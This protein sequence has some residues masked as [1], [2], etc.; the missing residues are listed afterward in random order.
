M[1]GPKSPLA[2]LRTR[3]DKD[4]SSKHVFLFTPQRIRPPHL[5]VTTTLEK[6]Y[7]AQEEGKLLFLFFRNYFPSQTG[8]SERFR[9]YAPHLHKL[10]YRVFVVTTL[11]DD[12]P[13][14]EEYEW[15]TV[16]RVGV[17]GEDG[18]L[19]RS[20]LE[21]FLPIL[22]ELQPAVVQVPEVSFQYWKPLR[23]LRRRGH[24]VVAVRTIVPEP[25][26]PLS[27]VSGMKHIVDAF[28]SSSL[29]D[30]FAAG[31]TAMRDAF[32]AGLTILNRKYCI[33][34][35]GVDLERFRPAGRTEKLQIRDRLGIA[36][37]GPVLLAV[38]TIIDR[39]RPHLAIE[40]FAKILDRYPDARLVLV[41]ENAKRDSLH[42]DHLRRSFSNYNDF[43][44]QLIDDCPGE[45]I[46]ATGEVS[47]ISDYYRAADLFVFTSQLEGLPNAFIEAMSSGLP[48]IS[49]RFT[50]FPET[51]LG[52]PGREFLIADPDAESLA[53]AI[54]D[55]LSDRSLLEDT[56]L[57]A[58]RFAETNLDLGE[59]VRDYARAY[60][61]L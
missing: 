8:A 13:E 9:R 61:G 48:V 34:P 17:D 6:L 55:L 51:E 2:G 54:D 46:M 7:K 59:T 5:T 43:I 41:G 56:G 16:I 24:R 47:N 27:T 11:Q 26:L 58:R 31:S 36:T 18:P 32:T 52:V 28:L 19:I 60:Q 20:L 1:A 39:K 10:G 23:S 25:P 12:L 22:R 40:A 35:H 53:S 33:I 38:G 15:E 42:S 44:S 4:S 57:A 37:T 3:P 29:V 49:T 21:T 30:A 50:G 45:S 14:F